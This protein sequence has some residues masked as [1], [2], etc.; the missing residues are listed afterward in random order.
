MCVSPT[1]NQK[2]EEVWPNAE[3]FDPDRYGQK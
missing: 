1:V 2:L 3:Q